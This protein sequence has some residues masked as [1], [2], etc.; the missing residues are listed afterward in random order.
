MSLIKQIGPDFRA[1]GFTHD[2]RTYEVFRGGS[3]PAVLVQHEIP[4]LHPGVIDF[5]PSAHR[6]WVHRV[7]A[8]SS[9]GCGHSQRRPTFVKLTTATIPPPALDDEAGMIPLPVWLWISDLRAPDS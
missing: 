6:R 4:G 3:G 2:R 5:R 8:P 1:F 9:G 7:R